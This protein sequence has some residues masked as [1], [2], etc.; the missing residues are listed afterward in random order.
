M[1]CEPLPVR[2]EE[3]AEL[4]AVVEVTFLWDCGVKEKTCRPDIKARRLDTVFDPDNIGYGFSH[5]EY[6]DENTRYRNQVRGVRFF[7]RTVGIGKKL[8]V[9]ATINKASLGA[10]LFTMATV[11]ADLLMIKAFALSKKYRARKFE[12]TPDFSEY[13][14]KKKEDMAEQVS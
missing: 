9:A 5:A 12:T 14:S 2:Y 10:S 4:G 7:F 13:M 1:K 6:V 11:V 3:V 8:S